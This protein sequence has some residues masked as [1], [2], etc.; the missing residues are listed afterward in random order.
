MV[1]MGVFKKEVEERVEEIKR[2]RLSRKRKRLQMRL[3]I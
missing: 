2:L 1:A 3:R